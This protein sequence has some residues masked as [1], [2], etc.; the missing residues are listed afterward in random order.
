VSTP[1]LPRLAAGPVDLTAVPTGDTPGLLLDTLRELDPQW[2]TADFDVA[3]RKRLEN[4][5]PV[6]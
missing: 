4:E 3:E 6:S 2:P 5:A 1:P